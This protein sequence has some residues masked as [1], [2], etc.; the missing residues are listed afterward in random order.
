MFAN[1]FSAK[2]YSEAS[3]QVLRGLRTAESTPGTVSGSSHPKVGSVLYVAS[4]ILPSI[5][6]LTQ[7]RVVEMDILSPTP[8]GP[9]L[10]PEFTIHACALCFSSLSLSSSAY[11]VGQRVRNAAPKHAL[12]VALGS[13][14]PRS[15]PATLAV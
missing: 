11:L 6:A 2:S 12:K 4:L 8:Y 9:P 7:F 14:I 3:G 10:H 5:M 15:V 13:V 1:F